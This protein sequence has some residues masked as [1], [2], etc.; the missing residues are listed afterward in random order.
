MA[1]SEPEE[2]AA[3]I[4]AKMLKPPRLAAE[5]SRSTGTAVRFAPAA[6]AELSAQQIS[7]RMGDP[8]APPVEREDG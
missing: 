1:R 7:D 4:A 2:T 3:V 5:A 6:S 8:A